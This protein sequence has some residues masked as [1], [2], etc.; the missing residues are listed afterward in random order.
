M[1]NTSGLNPVYLN[2]Q[3][4]YFSGITIIQNDAKWSLINEVCHKSLHTEQ[5]LCNFGISQ[6]VILFV[7]PM[8]YIFASMLS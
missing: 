6:W 1:H 2:L 4:D 3:N 7:K 5:I 8:F